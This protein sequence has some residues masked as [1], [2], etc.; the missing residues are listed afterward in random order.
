VVIMMPIIPLRS[1]P[2]KRGGGFTFEVQQ[3]VEHLCG[4]FEVKA[5]SWGVVVGAQEGVEAPIR[6][7]CEVSFARD[8]AA[9]TTDGV[10]D[11]ALLPGRVGIA[12]EGF[13]GE[14][15]KQLMTGK[16][17]A[18]VESNGLAQPRGQAFEE[19]VQMRGDAIGG[20][21]GRPGR[22]QEAGLA[23][24]N[25]EHGLAVLGEQHE[26]G[27]P[28][29]GAVAVGDRRRSF[30][31]G[32]TAFDQACGTATPAA[33]ETALALAARQ[34]VPPA[35]VLGAGDLGVDEAV[36]A[37]V[38]DHL[39]ATLASESAGDLLGRPASGEM[40]ENVAAQVGLAFEARARPASRLRLFLGVTWFVSDLAAA[41][42]P[43]LARDRRWRA[44]QSCRNLPDRAP[45]GL[46]SGNLASVLQ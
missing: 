3:F 18:I 20:L 16:L 33:A 9:H 10:F 11:A 35:V 4:C 28:M 37:L 42:A 31:Y 8:E 2:R 25:G 12:E 26:V 34:I 38:A 30:G 46:K 7:G 32:D 5:F 22:K 23:L 14:A 36:D 6:E 43:H 27:F 17:G 1:S 41:V 15:V 13:D 24:M 21:V 45:V 39:V 44:I 29:A 40:L 19:R